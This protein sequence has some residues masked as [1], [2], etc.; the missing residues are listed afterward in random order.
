MDGCS[1]YKLLS[2]LSLSSL[3]LSSLSHSPLGALEH[4]ALRTVYGSGKKRAGCCCCAGVGS[5]VLFTSRSL[6]YFL[7][8]PQ[9]SRE[10]KLRRKLPQLPLPANVTTAYY[11]YITYTHVGGSSVSYMYVVV[12]E[13]VLAPAT[14]A[15]RANTLRT[16]TCVGFHFHRAEMGGK[17]PE[18]PPSVPSATRVLPRLL[19][20]YCTIPPFHTLRRPNIFLCAS[21]CK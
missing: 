11:Y 19:E 17:F 15:R 5:L 20:H 1:E 9:F 21:E 12:N 2:P 18:S 4:Y 16:G 7:L 8:S 13:H 14:R 6:S 10:N 3:F